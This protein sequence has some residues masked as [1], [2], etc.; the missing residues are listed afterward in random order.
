MD[1]KL[2]R[3]TYGFKPIRGGEVNIMRTVIF[4]WKNPYTGSL[5]N[6]VRG[7][8]LGRTE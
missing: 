2:K 5:A 4:N 8:L 3:D 6:A 1:G 7:N